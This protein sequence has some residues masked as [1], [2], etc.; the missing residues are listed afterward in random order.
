MTDFDDMIRDS[1]GVF[2]SGLSSST[3]GTYHANGRPVVENVTVIYDPKMYEPDPLGDG[4]VEK[5]PQI[6][7]ET[8]SF[9]EK[10]KQNDRF[11]FD[12]IKVKVEHN[13][14]DEIGLTT[15]RVRVI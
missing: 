8:D 12:G 6:T 5:N 1:S 7:V 10:I 11:E 15:L 2:T 13:E 9:A 3:I 4:L 14:G